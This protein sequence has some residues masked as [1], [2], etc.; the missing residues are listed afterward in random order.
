L[1][2]RN[3]V[4]EKS[5]LPLSP[6]R[7]LAVIV[8]YKLT[9]AKSRSLQSLL[10]AKEEIAGDRFH[11]KIFLYDNTPGGQ[12]PDALAEGVEYEAAHANR[13]LASAYNR[14]LEIATEHNFDWFLTLDQDTTL[15]HSFLTALAHGIDQI[16]AIS[17]VAAVVPQITGEGKMLSPNYFLFDVLPRFYPKGFIGIPPRDTYAFNSASTLRVSAL[18]EIGGYDPMFWLDNSDAYLYRRLHL[19]RKRVYVAGDIQVDHE[20]ALFD[21]KQRVSLDRYQSIVDAGCAFW[22]LELGTIAGL[23]HTASLVYRL[24]NHWRRGDDPEIRRITRRTLWKRIFQ[25]RK[26]RIE[27]WRRSV[28]LRQ[29]RLGPNSDS[30]VRSTSFGR[31]TFD[32]KT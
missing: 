27:D 6:I 26:R 29:S 23:Y 18:R 14:A 22:D 11:L 19:H 10:A 9:P 30:D 20:F 1:Q 2:I 8:L 32:P 15:P 12:D 17:D 16:A 4:Q 3:A 7:L 5:G 13:G 24:Y 25:S 31:K 28:Q 21:I